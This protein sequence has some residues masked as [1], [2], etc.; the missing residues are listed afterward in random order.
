M[1]EAGAITLDSVTIGIT[2]TGDGSH[3]VNIIDLQPDIVER[4]APWSGTFFCIPP[5]AGTPTMQMG[6]DLDSPRPIARTIETLMPDVGKPGRPFF[7]E[8]TITLNKHEQ[9]VVI[10]R[11]STTRNQVAFRLRV[12]YMLG[13]VRKQAVI[14]DAGRPFRVT[15]LNRV[16]AED[17]SYQ[18]VYVSAPDYSLR[19][20][21][22]GRMSTSQACHS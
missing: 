16:G 20:V 17:V 3:D 2:L 22:T 9:Q 10:A 12:T 13:R 4:T 18:R 19:D 8:K 14:D 6:F 5:E 7:N 1:D 11:A 15:A 21:G